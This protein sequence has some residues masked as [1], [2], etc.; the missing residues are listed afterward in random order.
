[1]QK[2]WCYGVSSECNG[3]KGNCYEKK[4]GGG[5]GRVKSQLN[6]IFSRGP[7]LTNFGNHNDRRTS[8]L[9]LTQTAVYFCGLLHVSLSSSTLIEWKIVTQGLS[10]NS[11]NLQAS[12]YLPQPLPPMLKLPAHLS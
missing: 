2:T 11:R 9:F 1:M 6:N 5:H 10:G 3:K 12:I 7:F 8:R 4:R